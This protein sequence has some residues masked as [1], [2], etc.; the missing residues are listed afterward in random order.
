MQ[1][2]MHALQACAHIR[3]T[4]LLFACSMHSSM[5]IW[6]IAMQASSIDI[7]TAGV[8]PCIR[9]IERIIVLHMSAQFMQAGA[10]D[11]ICVEQTVHACS[12]AEQASMHACITDMSIASMP[13][14]FVM[15]FDM[16]SIIIESIAHPTSE[17]PKR[18]GPPACRQGSPQAPPASM[19][20]ADGSGSPLRGRRRG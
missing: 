8:I 16:A 17:K 3:Q 13:G 19:G 10:H 14:I 4:S 1:E 6:H 12:Q 11:I 18:A 9:I 20:C 5:H 2:S 7:M 15:S